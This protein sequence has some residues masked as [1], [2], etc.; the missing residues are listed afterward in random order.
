MSIHIKIG[1]RFVITSDVHQFI[2]NQRVIGKAG[3]S[4]GKERLVPLAYC[5]TIT[6]LVNVLV[7]QHVRDSD[8]RSISELA[9]KILRIGQKCEAAF[10]GVEYNEELGRKYSAKFIAKSELSSQEGDVNAGWIQLHD[11]KG[12]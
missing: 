9:A 7:H 3:E 6:Q 4:A 10:N 11:G 12:K 5:P 1:D 8:V 2:L